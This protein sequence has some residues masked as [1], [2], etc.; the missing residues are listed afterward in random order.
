M[1]A[2]SKKE[3]VD[4]FKELYKNDP[5]VKLQTDVQAEYLKNNNPY[6]LELW[7]ELDKN[8]QTRLDRDYRV[9]MNDFSPTNGYSERQRFAAKSFID[10]LKS[11]GYNAMID[12]NNAIVYNGAHNPLYV[13]SE[14]SL[15]SNGKTQSKGK[16]VKNITIDLNY[17]KI[18]EKQ[19]GRVW[20]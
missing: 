6:L 11:K 20:L 4:T 16:R 9:F 14:S 5:W 1:L 10:A 17:Y 2:P 8:A 3:K 7:D 15:S 13:F 19:G 18:K 12:D